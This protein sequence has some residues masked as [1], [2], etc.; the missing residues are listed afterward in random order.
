MLYNNQSKHILTTEGHECGGYQSTFVLECSM[1]GFRFR[2]HLRYPLFFVS[3]IMQIMINTV[4][5]YYY[6]A[7]V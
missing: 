4:A 3:S 6:F 7:I 5:I 2:C 1:F